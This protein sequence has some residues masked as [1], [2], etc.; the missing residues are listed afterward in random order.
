MIDTH[1][2][3]INNVD[4]GAANYDE[5]L[6]M[7]SFAKIQGID[8]VICTPHNSAFDYNYN[9]VIENYKI[10][11]VQSMQETGG[12]SLYLGCEINC[13]KENISLVIDKIRNKIYPTM[14]NTNHVLI[15]FDR[16]ILVKDMIYICLKIISNDYVPVIAH[17]ERYNNLNEEYYRLV[18]LQEMECKMQINAYSLENEKDE[19]IKDFARLIVRNNF[20]TYLGSDAHRPGHRPPSYK[21]GLLYLKENV[22]EEYFNKLVNDNAKNDFKL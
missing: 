15:E 8:K 14:N 21:E 20:A 18:D 17:V 5:S 13:S 10:L 2:H 1:M 4:D 22:T 9:K 16:D 11:R 7:L 6:T 19:Y 3:C 12:V